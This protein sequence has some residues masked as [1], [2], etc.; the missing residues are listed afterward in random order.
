MKKLSIL[1]FSIMICL[2]CYSDTNKIEQTI[3]GQCQIVK[4]VSISEYL[5][6]CKLEY[7]GSV[8]NR[9]KRVKIEVAPK[10]RTNIGTF[11]P[12]K[13]FGSKVEYKNVNEIYTN[14][15]QRL[16]IIKGIPWSDNQFTR[17]EC[18]GLYG[19]V[20]NIQMSYRKAG[21]IYN[22]KFT[23]IEEAYIFQGNTFA[24]MQYTAIE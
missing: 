4:Q 5:W 21:N 12:S 9:T 6:L 16:V 22:G 19:T 24:L 8:T 14:I 3:N 23:I 15:I 17:D 20:T 13:S 11:S 2:S 10:L 18:A 7:P 1:C